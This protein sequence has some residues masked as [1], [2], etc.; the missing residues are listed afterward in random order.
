MIWLFLYLV[1]MLVYW[2]GYEIFCAKLEKVC[3]VARDGSVHHYSCGVIRKHIFYNGKPK[4]SVDILL[5]NVYVPKTAKEI[6]RMNAIIWPVV[7]VKCF[8]AIVL[9]FT[10]LYTK[11]II[12][13]VGDKLSKLSQ[14]LI[15]RFVK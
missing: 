13:Y 1:S 9:D 12:A 3:S 10:K 2:L 15:D 4:D 8:I 14:K 7:L 5:K 11:Q 6:R